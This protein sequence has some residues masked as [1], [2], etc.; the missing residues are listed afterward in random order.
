MVDWLPAV[1]PDKSL[2]NANRV[3]PTGSTILRTAANYFHNGQTYYV[4]LRAASGSGVT[5]LSPSSSFVFISSLPAH[6]LVL[7]TAVARGPVAAANLHIAD[8]I[9]FQSDTCCYLV[10]WRDFTH[11]YDQG[12]VSY[13]AALLYDG[14]V[15]RPCSPIPAR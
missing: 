4:T 8:D 3:V 2:C 14:Q 12:G 1:L 9:D 15:R 5:G 6:G 10:Q 7:D 13:K 11:A